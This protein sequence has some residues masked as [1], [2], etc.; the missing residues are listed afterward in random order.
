MMPV[1]TFWISPILADSDGLVGVGGDL[2]PDTLLAAYRAGVFPWY[3]EDDPILWFSPDPRG[4]L[5][6]DAVHI[7]RRLKRTMDRSKRAVTINRCFRDVMAACG[8]NRDDGTWVTPD[9]LDA[10]SELHRLGYAHSIEVWNGD[11]LVG[12]VYGFSHGGFFA[13]ESMFHR[14][15][16]ASKI[17]LVTLCERLRTR[18]YALL[19][20]QVVS[21]HTA[22]F[23]A[24]S[25]PR[26]VYL[27][28]LNAALAM[29]SVTF[30]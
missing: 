17:A 27:D 13:A 21:P 4:V 1:S 8:E 28:Q 18:G 22:R 11:S 25:I 3:G 23:G 7:P 14:E 19:D 15:T 12:G 6:L 2:L 24:I 20:I 5:P 29:T 30:V 26:E 10:Y 16:D 9:M